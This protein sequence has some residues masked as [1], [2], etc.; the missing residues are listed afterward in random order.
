MCLIYNVYIQVFSSLRRIVGNLKPRNFDA[1]IAVH[2]CILFKSLR[3]FCNMRSAAPLH[4][5]D[6]V[7]RRF[8]LGF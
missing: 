8:L 2:F 1:E 4:C 3:T 6:P 5:D 7:P